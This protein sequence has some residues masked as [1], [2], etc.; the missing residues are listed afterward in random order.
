MVIIDCVVDKARGLGITCE[1]ELMNMVEMSAPT[2]H[3]LGNRR[4]E[5]F[6]F[7]IQDGNVRDINKDEPK[8]SNKVCPDCN[9]DGDYCMTCGN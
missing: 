6:I 1:E 5:R 8:K 4:Y 3:H 9:D 7:L 2:T